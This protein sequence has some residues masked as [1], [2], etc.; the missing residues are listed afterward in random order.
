MDHETGDISGTINI[1]ENA[2]TLEITITADCAGVTEDRTRTISVPQYVPTLP[3]PISEFTVPYG[4]AYNQYIFSAVAS[5]EL[6]ANFNGAI[7]S[8]VIMNK[9]TNVELF[10]GNINLGDN[11]KQTL[12]NTLSLGALKYVADGGHKISEGD[13]CS[14]SWTFSLSGYSTNTGSMEAIAS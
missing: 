13:V 7:V 4:E 14:V 6:N 3:D 12:Q 8:V 11:A 10:S 5:E 9:T 1:S 2:E